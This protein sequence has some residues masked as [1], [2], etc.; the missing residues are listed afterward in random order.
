MKVKV[1]IRRI[2]MVD[3]HMHSRCSDGTLEPEEL[4]QLAKKR[5]V[6][7]IALTDHDSVDGLKRAG[8]EAEKQGITLINGIEFSTDHFGKEVHILGYFLDL[9]DKKFLSKLGELKIERETRAK[10]ILKKLCDRGLELKMEDVLAEVTG[11]VLSRTHIANAMM[12][13]GYVYTRSEAFKQYLGQG[14]SAYVPK[15]ILSPKEAVHLIRENGGI[16]A[17]AHP[18]LIKMGREKIMK[19]IDELA[20]E[21]LEAVETYY[22]SYSKEEV[23]FYEDICRERGLLETGGSDFHGLNREGIQIGDVDV[24]FSVY[25]GLKKRNETRKTL[26]ETL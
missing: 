24:P 3:L 13:K 22:P 25:E 9:G 7:V 2:N 15:T 14:G 26:I 17:L 19:F 11:P 8:K 20:D 1:V 10:Q 12:K 18:K 23:E 5:G 21:G 6:K 16:A 4:V